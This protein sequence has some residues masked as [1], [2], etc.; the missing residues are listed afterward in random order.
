MFRCTKCGSEY[1]DFRYTCARCD[2]ALLL[3]D[4]PKSWEPTGAGMWRYRSMIPVRRSIS[5]SEGGSPL[6]RRRD[7]KDKVLLKVEGD[8]PT[9]SFKDR[10]TSVVI[11]DACNRGFK[12]TAVASTGNMGASVA[13]YSAYA[14]IASRVFI[15]PGIPE[16]KIAQ[17]TAY[18][19]E[20]VPVEGGFSDAVRR[21]RQEAEAGAYL[22]STGLNPYFIEGLKT[23]A[24]ELFEQMGVPDKV[25]VPTGTG[26]LL[27]AIFKGFRELRALGVID[28][29]PQMIAVQ[30]SEVAPIVE[31]WKERTEPRPPPQEA[32][33]IASAI[34]V[35][36][37]FNGLSAIDAMNRS[38][39][40]GLTVTDHQIVQAIRDLGRE[41]IFAEPAAAASMAALEQVERR[42]D[43]RVVLMVTGSGLKDPTVV[44]RKDI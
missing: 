27:T 39:G 26:G 4:H 24:F 35:K 31:A 21:A 18:G 43:D 41:G 19:A 30:S 9:G 34:L 8:N 7:S 17:I 6:V 11:S 38:G 3:E 13:A 14:N 42:P 37:P 33:T 25:V 23:I 32:T 28:R 16:E 12:L 44:L 1:P 36:S 20:L 40:Y 10:G 22:A 5:L 2:S 29:L 15:P